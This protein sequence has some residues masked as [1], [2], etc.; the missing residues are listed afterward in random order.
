MKKSTILLGVSVLSLLLVLTS[1]GSPKKY[2]YM[3]DVE[4]AKQYVVEHPQQARLAPGDRVAIVVSSS[5]PELVRPFN[6]EGFDTSMPGASGMGAAA[7]AASNLMEKQEMRNYGYVVSS[8][9]HIDFPQLGKLSVAGLTTEQ[10]AQEIE[11][12]I[13]QS[14][15]VPDARVS[16]VLANFRIYLLGAFNFTNSSS[17]T[18]LGGAGT[19]AFT[20]MTGTNTGVLNIYDRD[21]VNLLEALAYVGD[22][23][24]N[25]NVEKV[26]V[27]RNV[28]GK[29][30]TY[31]INMKRTEEIF[32][33]PAF[34]LQQ[35]DIVYVE[36]RYRTSELE[37]FSQIMQVVGYTMSSISS[38]VAL[39]ALY[40]SF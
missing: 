33:S 17:G 4:L 38:I 39:V 16:A 22:L 21:R 10:L 30:V 23:P 24:V 1:C 6:G 2:A 20:R 34:Y 36:A 9:G 27:I 3:Q 15:M 35:N 18:T 7:S 13:V 31:R 28:N 11:N 5:Y 25:A 40:R 14:K 8:T 29:F 19:S 37:S 12:R 26:N 32:N